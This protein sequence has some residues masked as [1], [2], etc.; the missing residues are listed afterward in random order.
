M[1]AF[2]R[3]SPHPKGQGGSSSQATNGRIH[4][5]K[6]HHEAGLGIEGKGY[7]PQVSHQ[8]N[9]SSLRCKRSDTLKHDTRMDLSLPGS[10][11]PWPRPFLPSQQQHEVY[12]VAADPKFDSSSPSVPETLFKLS[13]QSD[14][15]GVFHSQL[16]EEPHS[17]NYELDPKEYREHHCCPSLQPS[18]CPTYFCLL[19]IE[20]IC[21]EHLC[22]G[23]KGSR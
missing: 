7:S 22:H 13:Q 10:T 21:A 14:S 2:R 9:Q 16:A 3:S 8:T 12:V 5:L 1:D 20:S 19:F 15:T 17:L 11:S 6:E 18:T 23:L 4:P